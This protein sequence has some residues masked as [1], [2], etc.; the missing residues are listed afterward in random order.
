MF[1]PSHLGAVVSHWPARSPVFFPY[2]YVLVF[3]RDLLFY[4]EDEGSE[5]LLNVNT[6]LPDYTMCH[7]P[8]DINRLKP[9]GYYIHRL[10]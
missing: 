5:F 8:E 9:S 2:I 3:P 1:G 10:L 4:P 6:Y 7:I